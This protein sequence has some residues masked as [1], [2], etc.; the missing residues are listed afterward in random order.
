MFDFYL[1]IGIYFLSFL[2]VLYGM[3]GFDFNRFLKQGKIAQGQ[4]LYFV[5]CCIMTYL[6]GSFL[7]AMMYRFY[8]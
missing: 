3:S 5:L 7:M 6:L 1:R 4:V 8:K 2:L